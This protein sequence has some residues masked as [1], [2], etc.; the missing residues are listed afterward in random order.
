MLT[1][2]LRALAYQVSVARRWVAAVAA[3]VL[4]AQL[5]QGP[6]YTEVGAPCA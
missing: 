1:E 5:Q 6:Q 4:P 3:S 2:G